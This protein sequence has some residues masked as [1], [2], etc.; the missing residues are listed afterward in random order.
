[1]LRKHKKVV[2][3]D[4]LLTALAQMFQVCEITATPDQQRKLLYYFVATI[5]KYMSDHADCR[6]QVG[7]NL[8]IEK[9][10]RT[11]SELFRFAVPVTVFDN[12]SQYY[13]KTAEDVYRYYTE[14]FYEAD[15][16]RELVDKFLEN[17]LDYADKQEEACKKQV[18][19]LKALE[20]KKKKKRKKT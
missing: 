9:D 20:R 19:K 15:R 7:K 11:K 3:E 8:S 18:A 14:G 2:K 17:M 5:G 6:I 16:L 4:I 12:R 10:T 1:M 13:A